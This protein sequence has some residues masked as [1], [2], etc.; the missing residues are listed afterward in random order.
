MHEEEKIF[1][2]YGRE[3]GFTVPEGYFDTLR[4]QVM[5]RLPERTAQ[6]VA[7]K[8]SV[9][10]KIR[11]YV[12]MAAMFAGIWCM[13]KM[14]HTMSQSAEISLDNVP[15][16]VS[17][18]MTDTHSEEYLT[19]DDNIEEHEL[20]YTLSDSYS[21]MDEFEADFGVSIDPKYAGLAA[22]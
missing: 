16:S 10:Q 4:E 5:A 6:P 7:P 17:L 11:P 18:A 2:K 12:Y 14:F 13:M 9:W 20:I 21:N 19:G 15:Q 3:T 8:L 1:A 22:N